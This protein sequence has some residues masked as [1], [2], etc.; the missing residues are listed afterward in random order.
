[1]IF[2]CVHIWIEISELK[3]FKFLID[4]SLKGFSELCVVFSWNKIALNLHL[5]VKF[6]NNLKN[7]Q[8]N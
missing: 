6:G 7:R 4:H 5:V 2:V 3:K 8:Q 1:M